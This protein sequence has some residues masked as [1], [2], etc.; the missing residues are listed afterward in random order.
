[1]TSTSV[2]ST[3]GDSSNS[4]SSSHTTLDYVWL[5]ALAVCNTI[6]FIAWPNLF[7]TRRTLHV[8]LKP[9]LASK[10]LGGGVKVRVVGNEK[11]PIVQNLRKV[12]QKGEG[13][14]RGTGLALIT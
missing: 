13:R 10:S 3:P 11:D 8:A 4:S 7:E 1:M 12:S 2:G 6:P 9:L 5:G 14:E